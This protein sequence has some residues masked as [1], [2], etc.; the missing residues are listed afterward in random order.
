[1][2]DRQVLLE[3]FREVRFSLLLPVLLP[4]NVNMGDLTDASIPNPSLRDI[5]ATFLEGVASACAIAS[6]SAWLARWGCSTATHS[7][8]SGWAA[9]MK[10]CQVST[11]TAAGFA[12]LI[13]PL[14]WLIQSFG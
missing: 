11:F 3:L 4:Y 8:P 2:H 1:M 7:R 12:T 14:S 10:L 9:T 5:L 6:R 13:W